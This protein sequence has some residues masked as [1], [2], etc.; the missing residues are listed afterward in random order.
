MIQNRVQSLT[1][2][3][4]PGV[5][6]SIYL[7]PLN[8][9]TPYDHSKPRDERKSNQATENCQG[10]KAWEARCGFLK[11]TGEGRPKPKTPEASTCKSR[12]QLED[13]ASHLPWVLIWNHQT[14]GSQEAVPEAQPFQS[15]ECFSQPNLSAFGTNCLCFHTSSTAH[16]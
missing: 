8:N 16:C 14:K 7:L 12:C 5:S 4:S 3:S 15:W 13:A 10:E 11:L 9:P 2:M 1:Q 6:Q